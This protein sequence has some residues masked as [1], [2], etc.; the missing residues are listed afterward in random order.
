[1]GGSLSLEWTAASPTTETLR[2]VVFALAG[3]PEECETDRALASGIG[4]SPL[5][6]EL[7]ALAAA[8][9]RSIGVRVEV[10]DFAPRTQATLG[11][12]VHLTGSFTFREAASVLPVGG[13]GHAGHDGASWRW[14]GMPGGS[15]GPDR[16]R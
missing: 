2:L 1:M 9:G 12:D 5:H 8:E 16:T 7:P 3:C 6:V 13:P 14:A 10:V 11:Q 4:P 15:G